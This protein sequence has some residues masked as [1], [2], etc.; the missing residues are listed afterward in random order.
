V[1]KVVGVHGLKGNLKV[2][3]Y[4]ESLSVFESGSGVEVSFA[5]GSHRTLALSW[6]RPHGR[7]LLMNLESISDRD[8]AEGLVGAQLFIDKSCLPALEEDIYY[9]FQ[10]VGL[11]VLDRS[12]A[13][14]GK[15][16]RVIPTPGNDI[17]LVKGGSEKE[18]Q[19]ILI[20]AVGNVVLEIDLKNGTMTVDP[21]KGL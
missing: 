9:W 14:L 2:H 5:D 12:G 17:Y 21:P 19:E 6:I 16:A 18:P 13:L 20:P 10:L 11:K 1:G 15:L 7:G 8:Q 4:A 3:A